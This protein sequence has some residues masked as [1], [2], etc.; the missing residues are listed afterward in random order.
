MVNTVN[1]QQSIPKYK[2]LNDY[3]CSSYYDGINNNAEE[4]QEQLQ[5][6]MFNIILKLMT[7]IMMVH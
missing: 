6:S 7:N 4:E 5:D 2:K 1:N 3:Y